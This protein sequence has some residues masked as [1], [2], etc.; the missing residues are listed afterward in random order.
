M[1]FAIR[2]RFLG[3]PSAEAEGQPVQSFE[4]RKSFVLLAYLAHYETA[5]PRAQFAA[6]FWPDQPDERARGNLRRLLY[7]VTNVLPGCI[8]VDR[9]TVRLRECW[10]DTA[11]FEA[12]LTQGTLSSLA[13]AAEL[14]RST[15]LDGV[16]LDDCPELETWL[17]QQRERWHERAAHALTQLIARAHERHE[18]VAGLRSADRLLALDPW[19]EAA[20]QEKMRL[21]ALSG[22]RDSAL[23]QYEICRR[24]LIDELGIDPSP[25][26]TLLYEQI[27]DGVLAA[28]AAVT[29]ALQRFQVPS[30]PT[31]LLGRST[32]LA[33]ITKQLGSPACRLVT[34][35]GPGGIG[36]TR[37]SLEVAA[38]VRTSFAE[39]VFVD[40]T[41]I[42]TAERVVSAIAQSLSIRE[43][44][45]QRMLD[46]L[47]DALQ[48]RSML[49]MLDNFE[50][51]IP[52]AP[53]VAELLAGCPQLKVLVTSRE[54]LH[55]RGEQVFP[56]QPLALPDGTNQIDLAQLGDVAAVALFVARA[57]Q[58][59][60][61]FALTAENA[62]A[63]AEICRR[64]DGLPLAIELAAAR[65]RMFLPAALLQRLEN[66]LT[67]LTRGS[68]DLPTRQQTLQNTL[69]WSYNLLEPAEQ[70]VFARLGVFIGGWTL[71]AAE[72]ICAEPGEASVVDELQGLL[73]K[74]L[75]RHEPHNGDEPAFTMLE[76][77]REY[78][79]V[80]LSQQADAALIHRRH[81]AYYLALVERVAPPTQERPDSLHLMELAPAYGNEL[82]ALQWM[83]AQQDSEG[84]LRLCNGL[85]HLWELRVQLTEARS[86]LHAALALP[87]TQPS[88][89]RAIA[90]ETAG[91]LA[92]NQS[93]WAAATELLGQAINLGRALGETRL[94]AQFLRAQGWLALIVQDYDG[95]LPL[96]DESLA[97][98]RSIGDSGG[99]S[100]VLSL[101]GQI[102]FEQLDFARA[103]PLLTESITLL[104]TLGDELDA[105][106]A[107]NKLGLMAL[108]QDNLEAAERYL[109]QALAIFQSLAHP[110]GLA[111]L[112]GSLGWLRLAQQDY[113]RAA[114]FFEDCL[115]YSIEVGEKRPLVA[116]LERLACLAS[117]QGD[118]VRAARI[119]GAT[120][121]L[122]VGLMAP[123]PPVFA[124][125]H[126][127]YLAL[128]RAA[129]D[130]DSELAARAEG[131]ALT[132]EQAIAYAL[133]RS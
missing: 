46:S 71:T 65:I 48:Q 127:P 94:I 16:Y 64:L 88:I 84:S 74:Q 11:A 90:L 110:L 79:R 51:V 27:R 107:I 133:Q 31:L 99:I 83:L 87:S 77:M 4:S 67:L 50:H 19:R 104:H 52:A 66:R 21:L 20:H 96:F 75:I 131:A 36:K 43:A 106:W 13:S 28:P 57:M 72:T 33:W 113:A 15:F 70:L 89:A 44:D 25:E 35:V 120:T 105:A 26:T 118:A 108:Q 22:Q 39:I 101:Q 95:A 91:R 37:L 81:A 80:R 78:A 5:L 73:D 128:M 68:H 125:Q 56:L 32:E 12:L 116:A 23:A 97:L 102:A 8:E 45:E 17:T 130:A 69:D 129:L 85:A 29:P 100:R 117:A 61:S 18:W 7:N 41:V 126:A 30:P 123:L 42:D 14:Y 3:T 49:L 122:R 60:P 86:W 38:S 103:I 55:L 114:E 1:E 93:D 6:L 124:A 59:Q 40:L 121:A 82:A 111:W 76:T 9:Q 62:A 92:A 34:L 63:V 119:F 58:H 98:Y 10:T 109:Q 53:V 132:L 115:R 2:L 112:F 54:E 24:V 47:K